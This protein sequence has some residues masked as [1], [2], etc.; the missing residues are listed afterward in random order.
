MCPG[1]TD[2]FPSGTLKDF[3]GESSDLGLSLP[4]VEGRGVVDKAYSPALRGWRSP[5]WEL[6][7]FP[8]V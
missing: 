7:P 1:T 6:S 2:S 3:E 8:L 4:T 5:D